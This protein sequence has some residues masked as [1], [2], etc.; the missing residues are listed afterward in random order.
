MRLLATLLLISAAATGQ[1]PMQSWRIHFSAFEA[2]NIVEANGI[3][4]MAAKN[5][6]IQYDLQSNEISTLSVTSGLSDKSISAIAA[7]SKYIILG[8]D[9]GNIDLIE[10]NT[11]TNIPWLKRALISGSKTIFNILIDENIAYL[12]TGAGL[13]EVDIAKKEISNT[14]V[15]YSGAVVQD[16]VI[17][18]DSIFL[19]TSSGIYVAPKNGAFLNN[20]DN[21]QPVAGLPNYINNGNISAIEVF[22]DNLIIAL[23]N[24]NFQQDTLYK[25]T[26]TGVLSNYYE[27]SVTIRNVSVK[28]DYLIVSRYANT[29]IFDTDDNLIQSIFDYSF[30]PPPAPAGATYLDGTLWIADINN[31]MV[32]AKD[33]FSNNKQIYGNSPFLDGCYKIDI[34]KGK[35]AIAGG[36]LTGN[37][38]N[39][40]A[41]RGIYLFEDES[42][43]NINSRTH[44]DELADTLNW[45][46]ISVA[47]NPRNTEEVAF[48]SYSKGGL[49]IVEGETFVGQ[50]DQ[51]NSPLEGQLNNEESMI[52]PDLKYDKDGNLW[53]VNAGVQPLKVLTKDGTWHTFNLGARANNG[54]PVRLLIDS[55]GYKWVAIN[56]LG[57]VVYDDN[58]TIDDPSDDRYVTIDDSKGSG[59]LP[60]AEVK[61]IAEDI[62]GEI[63]IGTADGIAV[64][65]SV[66]SIFN[67]GF[68]DADASQIII[69][70]AEKE[71]FVPIFDKVTVS[72]IA[73]DGGNRKWIGTTASGVFCMSPNGKTEI[74]QFNSDN[75]PLVSN[76]IV[77]MAIDYESGEVFFVTD[78]GLISYRTDVTSGD[79]S[80]SS[81]KVFPNPVRPEYK[82]VITIEG[83]GYE[84]QVRITDIS[85]NLIYQTV[86]NG[87]TILWDGNRL[88]GERVQ[89]GVYLVWSA[90]VE[91]KGKNVAKILIIN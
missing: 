46:I 30:G 40:F 74:L 67:G 6:I 53:M 90:Q 54:F 55:R 22:D 79:N 70:D 45:D 38:K 20:V 75:S 14:Y 58:G 71:D 33:P 16:M 39:I 68:G 61:S 36:G 19:A 29:Q 65:Y 24:E 63:W 80:F 7:E 1:I 9:N 35:V 15:P 89:S 86:S 56:G 49:K 18:K 10:N 5:G 78:E 52:I 31:G 72:S 13:L 21:W 42:W 17:Y 51:Y 85:G 3:V 26:P 57:I 25:L 23:D 27:S 83:V 91:G 41:R 48:S 8:Y 34:T 32:S 60:S 82:G 4:S 81:V 64:F 73:V 88:T 2:V 76:S 37:L 69:F 87:G 66:G 11:I 43:T 12:S 47:V 59:D 62:D 77:D 84:S 44:P 50:Y 28:N